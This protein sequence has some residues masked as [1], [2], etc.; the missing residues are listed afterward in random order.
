[1]GWGLAGV[2]DS[3]GVGD[4]AGVGSRRGWEQEGLGPVLQV[5]REFVNVHGLMR[6]VCFSSFEKIQECA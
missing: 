2:V 5:V 3:S 4:P 6:L 1:M